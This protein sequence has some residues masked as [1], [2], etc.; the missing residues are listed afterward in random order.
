MLI[1]K[2]RQRKETD[3]NSDKITKK[4]VEKDTVDCNS[5]KSQWLP[6]YPSIKP[7]L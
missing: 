5:K 2:K 4:Q 7:V 1:T 3:L 6:A